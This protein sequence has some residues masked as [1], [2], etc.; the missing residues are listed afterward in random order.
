MDVIKSNGALRICLTYVILAGIW[1]SSSDMILGWLIA[2][3][4]VMARISLVKGWL[5]IA[6]TGLVLYISAAREFSYR[7]K[8]E[9]D[10]RR[11]NAD[12]EQR[13]QDRTFQLTAANTEMESF[14]YSVSHDLR[15]PLRTIEGLSRIMQEENADELG[16]AGL[17]RMQ[18]IHVTSL[19]MIKIMDALLQLTRLSQTEMENRELDLSQMAAEVVSDLMTADPA[20][21][22]DW[23]V[24][25]G[26]IARGDKAQ[27][28]IV[29]ENLL[30]NAWKFTAHTEKS[31]IE[32]SSMLV[33]GEVV[34]QLRDNGAGFNMDFADKLFKPFQRLHPASE[35][36]GTGIGLTIVQRV[37]LRHGGRIWATGEV[38]KGAVV[39]FTL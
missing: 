9:D 37:I 39:S 13:V 28:R 33:N 14:S 5:F 22:V 4:Q 2:D 21:E 32:F 38:G 23:V 35:F 20:R 3:P 30:Q 12:L 1:I 36:E 26:M 11:L 10:V 31:T 6:V 15:A 7:K 34:F 19:R 29:L 8:I 24:Q 18:M 16:E 25:P 17:K 27:M